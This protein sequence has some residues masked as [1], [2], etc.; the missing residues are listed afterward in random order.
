ML[1]DPSK[2]ELINQ[3]IRSTTIMKTDDLSYW[4]TF[5]YKDAL[6]SE[7]DFVILMLGKIMI[8][9]INGF[10]ISITWII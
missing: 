7:A 10:K 1:N 3:G 5:F 4:D 9:E 6:N 2:Y 8:K